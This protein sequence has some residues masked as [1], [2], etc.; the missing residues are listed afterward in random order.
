[1][2]FGVIRLRWFS[3]LTIK[4]KL[5]ILSLLFMAIISGLVSYTVLELTQQESDGMVINIAGRQRMLTQKFA[6]EFL[7]ANEI[8]ALT[9]RQADYS[10]MD[11]TKQLFDVS[12]TALINGGKTYLD[13]AMTKPIMLP[14]APV[15]VIDQLQQVQTLWNT[16]QDIIKRILESSPSLEL[17]D[18]LMTINLKTLTT[19]NDAVIQL[20]VSSHQKIADMERNQVILCFI[21]LV[22]AIFMA[23]QIAKGIT[24]PI[25][26]AVQTTQRIANGDLKDYQQPKHTDNE[27]GALTKNIEQMRIALHD[28]INVVQVNSRQMSHSAH[29]V[30]DVS[31]EISSSSK[32]QQQG[33]SEV[34]T[35]IDSLLETSNVVS[36]N[37]ANTTSFSQSTL[38]TAEQGIVL[39]ND[40]IKQ[41]SA[42]VGSVNSTAQQMEELKNFTVQINDITES[43]HNIADQTNLLALNAAIEAARAGEQG[44]GFAVVADEVRNLAARTSSSSRDISDLITQL[45]E[46]VEASVNSMHQVVNLVHHSQETSEKTVEAFTSMSEGIGKTTHDIDEISRFNQEQVQNLEYLD[47]KLKDLLTVLKESTNKARTTSMVANDL[48]QISEQLDHQLQGFVTEQ[49]HSL[50]PKDNEKR[51]TPRADNKIRVSLAQNHLTS[52]GLTSDISME[53]IK[54]RCAEQFDKNQRIDVEIHLPDEIQTDASLKLTTK[55]M[56]MEPINDY[57]S[58][59]LKFTHLSSSD[60]EQLKALFKYFKKPY[61]YNQ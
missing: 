2:V 48:Y 21:A 18:E 52:E 16:Q 41:L 49:S 25:L 17:L 22:I 58:Y 57:F 37:I 19:M 7:V 3:N 34:L 56:H 38:T 51:K 8:A 4:R 53:G 43:I 32:L 12:L 11:K 40:N 33:S 61:K 54:I 29:Q 15:A 55:L 6:K 36:D 60:S 30:S 44:R 39:V 20:S 23:S 35:A 5:Q 47:R 14:P 31:L 13:P 59:G 26:A 46:K 9:N 45:M 1:M 27:V 28:V 42:A 24:S 50:T 10:A